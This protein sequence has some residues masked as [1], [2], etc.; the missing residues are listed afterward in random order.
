MRTLL[1]LLAIFCA[2]LTPASAQTS[3]GTTISNR[4]S[5]VYK[6]SDNNDY[7]T[8]SNTV[9]VTVANVSGLR[10]LPD[11]AV[12]ASVV[13]GATNAFFL[14][15]VTNTGNF[16]NQ[17]RFLANGQSLNVTGPGTITAAVIDMDSSNTITAGDINIFSNGADVLHALAQ[18]ATA[19]VATP[20]RSSSA[21]R[22]R[23]RLKDTITKRPTIPRRLLCTKFAPSR[24]RPSTACAKR[25][26]TSA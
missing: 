13:P 17:V 3:G 14:F 11:N 21:T 15:T 10:I 6:D 18:N 5:A 7:S 23:A 19:T 22:R 1:A 16:A 12:N 24:L 20:C 25:A 8:V 9:T 4:A 2:F 26:A